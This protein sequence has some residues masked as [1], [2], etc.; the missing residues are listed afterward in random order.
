MHNVPVYREV[1]VIG[2]NWIRMQFYMFS[3]CVR[4][5]E[6]QHEN[7][8][9]PKRAGNINKETQFVLDYFGVQEPNL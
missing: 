2:H 8:Y 7:K 9:I 5:S 3:D 4:P 6:N 1:F